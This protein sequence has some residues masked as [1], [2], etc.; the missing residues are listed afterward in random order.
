MYLTMDFFIF[1]LTNGLGFSDRRLG[2][3][4]LNGRY[5][6]SGLRAGI[7]QQTSMFLNKQSNLRRRQE[8]LQQEVAQRLW[9]LWK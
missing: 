8:T 3:R 6:I 1:F 2:N 9:K 7:H 5:D 4:G